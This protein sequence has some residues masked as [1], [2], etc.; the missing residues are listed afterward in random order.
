MKVWTWT[1]HRHRK[2]QTI[3]AI[4]TI[5]N[6]SKLFFSG[7]QALRHLGG[8][9]APQSHSTMDGEGFYVLSVAV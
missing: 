4:A 9:K 6:W 1:I 7:S 2:E 5:L 3:N 8:G